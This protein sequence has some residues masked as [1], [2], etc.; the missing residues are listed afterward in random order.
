ML[1][2]H[3][4]THCNTLQHTATH[5]NTLQHTKSTLRVSRNREQIQHVKEKTHT[6]DILQHTATHCNTLHYTATHS[7]TR[8]QPCVRD[9]QLREGG[10][11]ESEREHGTRGGRFVLERQQNT[12]RRSDSVMSVFFRDRRRERVVSRGCGVSVSLTCRGCGV[13]VSLTC[14]DC[15]SR[16]AVCRVTETKEERGRER[17]TH[18]ESARTG[19]KQESIEEEPPTFVQTDSS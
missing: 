14:Q 2:R 17:D 19:T 10:K 5:C 11:D 4:A 9:V 8:T 16:S 13:S 12:E 15:H 18:R 6:I 3:T 7:N 1:K